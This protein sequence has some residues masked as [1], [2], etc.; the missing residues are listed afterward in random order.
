MRGHFL[1]Q[2]ITRKVFF[3]HLQNNEEQIMWRPWDVR[4]RLRLPP[5]LTSSWYTSLE[6]SLHLWQLSVLSSGS[7]LDHLHPR[8][9]CNPVVWRVGSAAASLGTAA[10]C[11]IW[12]GIGK[13]AAA[14]GSAQLQLKAASL[15]AL[16]QVLKESGHR[17]KH[18][19]ASQEFLVCHKL[20][21]IKACCIYKLA[22]IKKLS[23]V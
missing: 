12:G 14:S 18:V 20:D 8:G 17:T 7:S 9:C 22:K 6:S 4:N 3:S 13:A 19:W 5:Q 10:A 11:S 16:L 21:P 2:S 1:L 23:K 15:P